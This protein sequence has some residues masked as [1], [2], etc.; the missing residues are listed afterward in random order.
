MANYNLEKLFAQLQAALPAGSLVGVGWHADGSPRLD[1]DLAYTPTP[2]DLAAAQAIIEAHDPISHTISPDLTFLKGDDIHAV[3][4]TVAT[5][6][7]LDSVDL[8]VCGQP[9][10]IALVEGRGSFQITSDTP[11]ALITVAG[12]DG[13]MGSVEARIYVI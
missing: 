12:H 4:I 2:A 8:D 6:P 13:S 9:L 5:D 11:G 10:A 1:W 3:T 7:A